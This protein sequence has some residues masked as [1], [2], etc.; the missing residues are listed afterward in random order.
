MKF[1]PRK[2]FIYTRLGF[3]FFSESAVWSAMIRKA[4][5][6]TRSFGK[7]RSTLLSDLLFVILNVHRRVSNRIGFA[8]SLKC[9]RRLD[10]NK[11]RSKNKIY[12]YTLP[13]CSCCIVREGVIKHNGNLFPIRNCW[14]V[15]WK[16]GSLS[17]GSE[18][19]C[20]ELMVR[21]V[22]LFIFL[23]YANQERLE[24]SELK[25]FYINTSV[26]IAKKTVGNK[27]TF[28]GCCWI[29]I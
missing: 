9:E 24:I 22:Y 5:A 11:H 27:S 15:A 2:F 23:W 3:F 18:E 10:E 7:L 19:V 6:N 26:K 16:D 8:A 17:Y 12:I 14:L 25:T 4:L 20:P 21:Y 29:K 13:W 1:T 28:W